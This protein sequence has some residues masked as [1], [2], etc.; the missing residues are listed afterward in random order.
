M[1][2]QEILRRLE[3]FDGTFPAEAM[4]AA[5]AGR[6]EITPH[7]LAILEDAS[8]NALEV[9]RE[10]ERMDFLYAMFLLAQFRET[11]AYPLMVDFFGAFPPDD[12]LEG[13]G[14]VVTEYSQR[15]LAS[16]CGGDDGPIRGIIEGRSRNEWVR[17]AAIRALL[18]LVAEGEK[19]REEVL[20]YY[21]GL[22]RGGLS[23]GDD[24]YVWDALV[25]STLDLYPEDL[26]LDV[27]RAIR[28]GYTNPSSVDLE[29]V[30]RNRRRGKDLVLQRNV[31]QDHHKRFIH[32]I[33]AE[34][35]PWPCFHQKEVRESSLDGES[36][37]GIWKDGY[38]R[39]YRRDAPKVGRND[40][41]P[42]G[43]GKKF[44]KCCGR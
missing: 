20:D 11:R 38:P 3:R 29:D 5:V 27:E 33:E 43:S 28:E 25:S 35:E 44:K 15:F 32:D 6:E 7:L 18:V 41:C 34:M 30:R 39:T 12:P 17:D 37:T 31:F 4:E 24:P 40:P 8:N 22:F 36:E 1:E 21:K 16:V 19:T 14:E 2:I 23:G 9:S 13:I 10:G 42:C 26:Y